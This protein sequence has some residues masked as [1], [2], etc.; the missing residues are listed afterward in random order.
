MLFDNY[1][2]SGP[3]LPTIAGQTI[4]LK[5]DTGV[6]NNS[7]ATAVAGETVKTWQDQSGNNYH[8]TQAT[9]GLRPI[10]RATEATL[11]SKPVLDFDGVDNFLL[12]TT[13]TILGTGRTIFCAWT[14]RSGTSA[15]GDLFSGGAGDVALFRGNSESVAGVSMNKRMW[16]GSYS[17]NIVYEY[18]VGYYST[19][20]YNGLTSVHYRN[21]V[22]A[23]AGST[24]GS[25]A[26]LGISIGARYTGLN[27]E[28]MY[29][30]EFIVYDSVLSAPNREAVELYLKTKYGL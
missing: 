26:G 2:A 4:W 19:F 28:K 21:G 24:T 29:L 6:L 5:A 18:A 8:L 25:G 1:V 14:L 17:T 11:N 27:P 16:N 3:T 22:S 30:A 12:R 13:D 10:Y 9:D 23:F 7:D 15:T 20:V